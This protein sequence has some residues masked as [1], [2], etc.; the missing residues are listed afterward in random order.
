LKRPGLEKARK[1][2]AEAFSSLEQLD[3]ATT[4]DE[5]DSAWTRFLTAIN[6]TYNILGASSR[7]DLKSEGWFGKI[8]G[9]R[10]GDDL[11]SYLLHARNSNDHGVE[12]VLERDPARTEVGRGARHVYIDELVIEQGKIKTLR[13]SQDGGPIRVEHIPEKISLRPVVDRGVTY[14]PPKSFLGKTIPDHSPQAV[15]KVALEF[16]ARVFAEAE[17]FVL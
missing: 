1:R 8:Q 7:G 4:W 5:F 9:Q 16:M 3:R 13:G 10:R 12:Q 11:L 6:A 17:G 14:N 15:G 2:L